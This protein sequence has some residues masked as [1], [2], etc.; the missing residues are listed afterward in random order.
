MAGWE[1][2]LAGRGDGCVEYFRRTFPP[3]EASAP[4]GWRVVG[5]AE[6]GANRETTR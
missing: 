4:P 1:A 3:T 2:G 6:F 5:P